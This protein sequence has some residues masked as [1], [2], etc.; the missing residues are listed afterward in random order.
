MEVTRIENQVAEKA[1]KDALAW[2][3]VHTEGRT[4][5]YYEVFEGQNV[6]GRWGDGYEVD[7]EIQEDTYVSRSHAHVLVEQDFLGRFRFSLWDDGAHRIGGRTSTNGTYVN[8]NK[9]RLP[10]G[11]AVFLEDGDTIQV[12]ETKLVFKLVNEEQN[13]VQV[14]ATEV[15]SG[16]YTKTVVFG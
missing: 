12:G 5:V 13:D 2:L 14:V 16:E 15:I 4:P 6:F 11:K 10:G 3:I 1:G 7:I 8:G 9:E